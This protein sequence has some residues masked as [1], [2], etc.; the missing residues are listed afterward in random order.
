ME[1]VRALLKNGKTASRAF[2][3]APM[4]ADGMGI[5]TG[6]KTT[7]GGIKKDGGDVQ[8]KVTWRKKKKTPPRM[9]MLFRADWTL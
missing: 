2:L 1:H 5:T 3:E 6:T 7:A 9:N 4:A 8:V